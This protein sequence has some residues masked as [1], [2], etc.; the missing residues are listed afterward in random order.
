M[1]SLR[2]EFLLE[3]LEP[4]GQRRLGDEERVGGAADVRRPRDLDEGLDLREQH[5]TQSILRIERNDL[6]N[7]GAARTMKRVQ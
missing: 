2:R 5:I 6:V 1:K 7:T 3:P 4:R